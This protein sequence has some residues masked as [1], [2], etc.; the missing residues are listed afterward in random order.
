[1]TTFEVWVVI[2]GIMLVTFLT[3]SFFLI[4]GQR[5][6]LPESFQPALRYAPAAALIAIIVPEM[7][8]S[9]EPQYLEGFDWGNP[10]F[11]GGVAGIFGFLISKSM[12]LTIVF[13]MTTFTL[14]RI[15]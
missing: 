8:V 11:W 2:V 5:F 6:E 7:F 14:L 1:M 4:M 12:I 13:G 3:R 9:P 10:H 15:F